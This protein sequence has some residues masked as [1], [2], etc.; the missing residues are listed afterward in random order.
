MSAHVVYPSVDADNPATL[1][2]SFLMELLRYELGFKGLAVSDDLEMKA[3]TENMSFEEATIRGLEAGL[4]VFVCHSLFEAQV[5]V[6]E[7]L[8]KQAESGKFPN[9]V[10]ERNHRRVRDIKARHFRVMRSIDRLHAREL[11]GNREHQRIARRLREGKRGHS[12]TRNVAPPQMVYYNEACRRA[13]SR[14]RA[15]EVTR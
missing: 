2:R 8:L 15:D 13:C 14:D 3:I 1:S 5:T 12:A 10:W 11:V 7:T 4:D 6:L 9:H